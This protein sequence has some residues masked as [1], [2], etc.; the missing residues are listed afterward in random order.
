M[1]F[2]LVEGLGVSGGLETVGSAVLKCESWMGI[3][4]FIL[5]SD[6]SYVNLTVGNAVKS[7][8]E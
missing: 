8:D 2:I 5:T 3:V 6:S 1:L 7:K 4:C